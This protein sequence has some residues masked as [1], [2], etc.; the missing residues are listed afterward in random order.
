MYRNDKWIKGWLW[1][2]T[3]PDGKWF[4]AS[5]DELLAALIERVAKLEELVAQKS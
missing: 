1:V 5:Y 4:R 3:T 2:Q